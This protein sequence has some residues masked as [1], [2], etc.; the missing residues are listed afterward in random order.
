MPM[1]KIREILRMHTMG[2]NQSEIAQSCAV[3]RAT[4][5]DYIRRA[6]SKGIT[7]EQLKQ[8]S[9]SEA[10]ELLGKGKFSKKPR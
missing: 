2:Y 9:D 4:V 10:K 3:A 7:Y 8:I 6:K 1:E 5:Q